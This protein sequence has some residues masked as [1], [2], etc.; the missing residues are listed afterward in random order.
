MYSTK[1]I[2]GFLHYRTDIGDGVRTGVVFRDCTEK[3]E[4]YCSFYRY[5]PEHEFCEDSYEKDE[6]TSEELVKYLLEEKTMYYARK[7]GITLLGR[8]PLRD[9]FFCKELAQGLKAADTDLQ[10]HTCGMCSMT[11][12]EMMDRLVDLY[13]LRVFLPLFA[14]LEQGDFD[15]GAQ[16]CKVLDFLEE[17][18]T[19]Y[20]IL[21]PILPSNTARDAEE[22]AER[23]LSLRSLKSVCLDFSNSPLNEE[24]QKVFR[25]AFLK[26]KIPLY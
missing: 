8:E 3:C 26:R 9:P 21:I 1:K 4:K 11:A 5:I 19:P 20:R 17:R 7:I 6:Y 10:I 23:I 13:V 25:Y 12:F 2:Q 15:R 16:V 22:L 18:R 24:E 14:K